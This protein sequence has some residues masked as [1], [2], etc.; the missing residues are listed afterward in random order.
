MTAPA[1]ARDGPQGQPVI[2]VR[3]ADVRDRQIAALKAENVRLRREVGDL[4]AQAAARGKRSAYH[5]RRNALISQGRWRPYMDAA[6]VQAHVRKVM[7]AVPL[8]KAQYAELAGVSDGGIEKMLAGTQLRVL[9]GFGR[10]LLTVTEKSRPLSGKADATGTRRRLQALAVTGHSIRSIA[11]QLDASYSN[12]WKIRSGERAVIDTSTRDAVAA[13]YRV[14]ISKAPPEGTRAQRIAVT[15][16]RDFAVAQKWHGPG[17]WDD[18]DTDGRPEVG[19]EVRSHRQWDHD[20]LRGWYENDGLSVRQIAARLG[21]ATSIRT[22]Y[23]HLRQAG[24]QMR[25]APVR[26]ESA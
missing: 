25:P 16:T 26:K 4:R 5:K 3:L 9:T 13:L 14:L 19:G 6:P 23:V 7:A 20:E 1:V 21:P 17:E 24:T 15:H 8:S 11:R 10:K 12:L 22:V 18:I 2:D